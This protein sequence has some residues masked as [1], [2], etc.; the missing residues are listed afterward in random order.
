MHDRFVQAVSLISFNPNKFYKNSLT[1]W[2]SAGT[3]AGA[4]S[5]SFSV[6]ARCKGEKNL[7]FRLICS[8]IWAP[9]LYVRLVWTCS[10]ELFKFSWNPSSNRLCFIYNGAGFCFCSTFSICRVLNVFVFFAA[11]ESLE[12]ESSSE[13]EDWEERS[14]FYYGSF[15]N[16]QRL[17]QIKTEI[18]KCRD[19]HYCT[20]WL[21]FMNVMCL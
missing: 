18:K 20:V 8:S 4:L 17:K 15:T 1:V 2:I 9:T 11:Q 19:Q 16:R 12:E 10:C 3:M 5:P 6:K 7:S 14:E 13:D 21:H